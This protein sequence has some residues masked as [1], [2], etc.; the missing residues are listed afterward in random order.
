MEIWKTCVDW[1]NHE[2]SNLGNVRSLEFGEPRPMRLK[3]CTNGYRSTTDHLVHR[4]VAKAF[5][6]IDPVRRVVN[7]KDGD[8]ANNRVENLEWSTLTE[9]NRY[10]DARGVRHAQTNPRRAHK[11]T[12]EI[13]AK[14]K[15]EHT[16]TG[17][18]KAIAKRFNISTTMVQRI[19]YNRSWKVPVIT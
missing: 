6:P 10:A 19:V 11:L 18:T 4:L 3:I 16:M 13:V 14:I 1:A 17:R 2:V 5:L 7:H 15:D 9:N 12:A 8:K